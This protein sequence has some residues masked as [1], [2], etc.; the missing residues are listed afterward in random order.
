[1]QE[2]HITGI[3]FKIKKNNNEKNRKKSQIPRILLKIKKTCLSFWNLEL[4]GINTT[5]KTCVSNSPQLST[6][7]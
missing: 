3:V 2:S 4:T 6:K 1:M 7:C 5:F